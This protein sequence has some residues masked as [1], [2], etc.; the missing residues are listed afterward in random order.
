MPK[1]GVLHLHY[2]SFL[3]KDWFK[4]VILNDP[5]C[6]FNKATE[7]FQYYSTPEKVKP[8]YESLPKLRQEA[9][10]QEEFEK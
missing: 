7:L 9:A 8:G 10:S 5:K 2:D 3:D 1:G 6:Y 4:K